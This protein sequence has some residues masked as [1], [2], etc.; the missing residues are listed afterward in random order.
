MALVLYDESIGEE[1]E[2]YDFLKQTTA[3]ELTQLLNKETINKGDRIKRKNENF[4]PTHR[5]S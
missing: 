1:S 4:K 2:T 5:T 3:F